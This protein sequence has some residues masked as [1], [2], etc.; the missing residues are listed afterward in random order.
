[1][2]AL[3]AKN[4]WHIHQMDVKT[5]FLY[6]DINADIFVKLPPGYE[7]TGK[8]CKLKKALYGLK[9]APRIWYQTLTKALRTLGYE[10]C[11][12]D[13][14]VFKK[15]E[16]LILAYVDDLLIAGPDLNEINQLKADL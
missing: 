5:A 12:H 4:N 7:Q 14:A 16:T 9:Q 8:V 2:F 10:P 1:M 15:G 6:G 3:A 13:Y 11:P